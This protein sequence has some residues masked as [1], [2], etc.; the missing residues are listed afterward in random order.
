MNTFK[1]ILKILAVLVLIILIG[2]SLYVYTSTPPLPAKTERIIENVI[3]S[4]L[5]EQVKGSSGFVKSKNI[6]I[7]Y[8]NIEP[9]DSIKGTVLLIMGIANDALAWP[10]AFIQAF[11]DENYRV[12]RYDHRGTGM[13]DWI[14]DWNREN[15][16]SLA[17]MADDCIAILDSLDID[18]A[19]VIGI[20]MGGMIAQELAINY[21]NRVASLASIMSSGYVVDPELPG[22][23]KEVAF[24]LIKAYLKYGLIGGE[25]NIM[26]L[27]FVS[28]IILRGNANYRINYKEMAEQVL[29]NIRERKGYNF[30]VSEQHQTAVYLSGSRYNKLKKLQMPV[31]IIHGK[32][33]PFIPIEH[34]KKCASIIPNSDSLWLDDLGHD[35]PDE[36]VD[37]VTSRI[38]INIKRQ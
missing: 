25:E 17:D 3:H 1:K 2:A 31:L 20:S 7:W 28:R 14:K 11:V 9:E 35:I 37:T 13:S 21:Q 5:P 26:K 27:N 36:F 23:S 10:K 12:I 38:I 8:E 16:Y 29:Y 6:N 32:N 18:K 19:H 33:D 34:G 30:N 4:P 24:N 15:P 22:L